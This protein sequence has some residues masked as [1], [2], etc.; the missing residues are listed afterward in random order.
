M[1]KKLVRILTK[2]I[3]FIVIFNMSTISIIAHPGNTDSNGGHTCRTNCSSW[4][5]QYGEYHY[6]NETT[7]N[8]NSGDSSQLLIGDLSWIFWIFLFG[9]IYIAMKGNKKK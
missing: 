2:F 4:G 3:V 9:Y 5:L 8:S 1:K 7:N 6:H